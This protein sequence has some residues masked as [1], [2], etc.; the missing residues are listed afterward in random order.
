MK[1]NKCMG[2][3]NILVID[4]NI[5][6]NLVCGVFLFISILFCWFELF[7]KDYIIMLFVVWRV[8]NYIGY[9][10]FDIFG[11][12]DKCIVKV[13]YWLYKFYERYYY[14][15]L[16]VCDGF[17]YKLFEVLME[18]FVYEYWDKG[19]KEIVGLFFINRSGDVEK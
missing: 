10:W 16:C 14:F 5:F 18:I 3:V 2:E 8:F 12:S 6:V 13:F 19:Y 1:G 7:W 9:F 11:Y 15:L 17:E 4:C